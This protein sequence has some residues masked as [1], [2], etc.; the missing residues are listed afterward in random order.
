MLQRYAKFVWGIDEADTHAAGEAAVRRTEEFFRQMGC[1]V[2]LSD[3][4]PIKID[5]AEIVEH[6]ERGDQ[7]ALGERR[8]IGLADVRTILQ[9]AA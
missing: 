8:D 6:L 1:P 2:R 3:M 4:A 9:M 7:T 5:P